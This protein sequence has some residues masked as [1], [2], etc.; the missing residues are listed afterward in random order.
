MSAIGCLYSVKRFYWMLA[1]YYT[2]LRVHLYY[3]YTFHVAC[4][5]KVYEVTGSQ[6]SLVL[7]CGVW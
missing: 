3:W 6:S 1:S 5:L 4:Y 7:V 2:K